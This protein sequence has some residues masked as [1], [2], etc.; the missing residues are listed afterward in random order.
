MFFVV[1]SGDPSDGEKKGE[2]LHS[3]MY[4]KFNVF[5]KSTLEKTRRL[6]CWLEGNKPLN[7]TTEGEANIWRACPYLSRC[8]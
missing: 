2:K 4:Y 6:E 5:L 3:L 1:N 7:S 8:L